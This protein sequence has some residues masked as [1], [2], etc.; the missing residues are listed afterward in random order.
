M[1]LH[2][3]NSQREANVFS[4]YFCHGSLILRFK[5]I[6]YAKFAEFFSRN[7]S[8]SG[9]L[10]SLF[11]FIFTVQSFRELHP[12]FRSFKIHCFILI[13]YYF[14]SS[15]YAVSHKFIFCTRGM[16]TC[17]FALLEHIHTCT[18][19]HTSTR[20]RMNLELR[21]FSYKLMYLIS[22]C[23]HCCWA[24]LALPHKKELRDRKS[25]SDNHAAGAACVRTQTNQMVSLSRSLF[26]FLFFP[27]FYFPLIA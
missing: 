12:C 19:T 2:F 25:R 17:F 23:S 24:S 4:E 14:Y 5:F 26:L 1:C 7:N 20:T 13:Y 21:R 16:S 10:G 27:F 15:R 3:G 11:F 9:I 22:H 18:R 8:P 6:D